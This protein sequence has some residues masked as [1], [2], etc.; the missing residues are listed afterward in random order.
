MLLTSLIALAAVRPSAV[1]AQTDGTYEQLTQRAVSEVNV[2]NFEEG[3]A[4]FLRAHELAPNARTWRG[5][6]LCAFELRSYVEATA[7]LES[8]LVD[9]NKPL[10][11]EQRT[12]T[13]ELLER[14]RAFV[15]RYRVRV[16]PSSAQ[17]L[18]DGKPVTLTKGILGLDPGPHVVLV[19]AR[20]HAEQRLELRVGAGV[21]DEL[22][23]EL[24]A[25]DP[26]RDGE[27]VVAGSDSASPQGSSLEQLRSPSD[28]R[29]KPRPKRRRVWTWTLAVSTVS[30]AAVAVGL[31]LRVNGLHDQFVACSQQRPDCSP[32]SQSGQDALL[33]ARISGAVA[34][35]LAIGSIFAF[36]YEGSGAGEK[37]TAQLAV[38][39]DRVMLR[40]TF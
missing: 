39:P 22:N 7:D 4:L 9:P 40:G 17:V 6:G 30:A 34:G 29:S 2:G 23:I 1:R 16:T 26:S 25:T 28:I 14:A 10:T 12:Q 15:S 13:R 37:G 5:L 20:G 11:A 24:A 21:E 8:A 19:R 38:G 36:A 35:A 18:V 31:R 32:L 3:H 27:P 33:G